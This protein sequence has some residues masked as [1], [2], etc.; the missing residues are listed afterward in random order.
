MYD[1]KRIVIPRIFPLILLFL[2]G[3]SAVDLAAQSVTVYPSELYRGENLLTFT[4]PGGIERIEI[5]TTRYLIADRSTG[6]LPDCPESVTIDVVARSVTN[7]DEL[8]A[9]IYGCDGRVDSVTVIVERW[10]ILQEFTGAIEF[11]SDTCLTPRIE[12]FSMPARILDTITVTNPNF[13]V[14]LVGLDSVPH[15]RGPEGYVVR[16]GVPFFYRVCYTAREIGY[17]TDTILLRFRRVEPSGPHTHYTIAKVISWAGVEPEGGIVEEPEEPTL[18]DRPVDPTPFRNIL[19][20]SARSVPQKGWFYGNYLLAGHL[21]GYGATD[22]LTLLAGGSFVPDF[23]AR[24]Y[25]GTLGV[26]Y[27][28]VRDGDFSLAAGLQVAFSS[29]PE[30][31]IRTIAPYGIATYGD[32]RSAVTV[33][34]GYGFKRHFTPLEEFDRDA[35]VFGLGGNHEVGS[36]WKIAAEL[37]TIESSG[38][39]PLL[40]TARRFGDAWAIDFGLGMNLAGEAGIS[41]NDAL[42]G[43]IESLNIVPYLSGMWV[44]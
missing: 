27:E 21:A 25:L 26:K 6:I 8:T 42:S 13:T 11:G 14:D 2:L 31:D 3:T 20:P 22:R 17:G 30:S 36:G 38:I 1:E 32:D 18:V 34:A 12:S 28:V 40:V 33:A 15:R 39:L 9:T 44:F 43:E 41:F 7:D 24:F 19:I 23:L 10:T 4:M 5:A 29:V 35:F 16:P 37:A